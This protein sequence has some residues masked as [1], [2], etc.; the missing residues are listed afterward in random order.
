MKHPISTVALSLAA[1]LALL[2][3]QPAR[4][5][6]APLHLQTYRADARSFHVAS[7]LVSG[8]TEAVLIDAQFTRADAHRLVADVLASGKRLKLV[9]VSQG[10]PDY[11]FGLEVIHQAFPDARIVATPATV[12]HIRSS[13]PGKLKVWGPMLGA[14]GPKHPIV[15]EVLKGD[16]IELEGQSLQVVGLEGP[17]GFYSF[18][19]IPSIK[20]VVG[21]VRVFGDMHLWTSDSASPA[22]RRCWAQDLRVG[23]DS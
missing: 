3:G 1:A 13:L 11:Y 22:E 15:P 19:W 20:A 9:Y 2:L 18:V 12:A 14:N 8:R 17:A 4:A 21:G 16:R 23:R 6:E 5:E 10:D 7:V